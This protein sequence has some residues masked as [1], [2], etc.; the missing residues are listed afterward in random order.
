MEDVITAECLMCDGLAYYMGTLGKLDWYRCA[1]CGA[2][3][4]YLTDDIMDD[5]E[6]HR[7]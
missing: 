5:S 3:F 2:Q 7:V 4:N 1:S 6:D